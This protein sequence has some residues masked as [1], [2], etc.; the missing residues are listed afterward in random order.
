VIFS[1][2]ATFGWPTVAG[3]GTDLSVGPPA[4]APYHIARL[5]L[6]QLSCSPLQTDGIGENRYS[7]DAL[8]PFLEHSLAAMSDLSDS[9]WSAPRATVELIPE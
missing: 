8:L 9:W 1:A 5:I 3:V 4:A 7:L 2:W 6:D